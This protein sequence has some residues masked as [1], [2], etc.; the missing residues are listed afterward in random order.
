MILAEVTD[1]IALLTLN[2]KEAAN[3]LSTELL[4]DA[5]RT[6][7]QWN[8]DKSVRVVLLTGS[9]TRVFCAGADLKERATMNE[10]EVALAVAKIGEFIETV[11]TLQK[12][13]IAV[14][15]GACIGGG[16]ELALACD[17]RI[18]S[19]NAT[20][21]LTETGLGIIPGA[22]G[23]QRLPRLIGQQLASYMIF[24]GHTMSASEAFD[25]GLVLSV[26]YQGALLD[27]A[28]DIATTIATKAPL[29]IASAKE[30]IRGGLDTPLKKGLEVEKEAYH[31]IIQTKDRLEGL[32]A[33]K[34]K[35][36]PQFT[37]E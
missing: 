37:G 21:A 31:K 30:A 36:R 27:E 32:Q 11:A 2:R 18:S 6:L 34:E 29:A 8:E 7:R 1:G 24:T 15:Q 28:M 12:P 26:H 19:E 3:A 35:R 23:T 5:I 22:G 16:L 14:V 10:E 33:F 9:G 13:T 4:E 20:F 17:L 25:R